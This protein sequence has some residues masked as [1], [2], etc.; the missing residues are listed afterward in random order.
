MLKVKLPILVFSKEEEIQYKSGIEVEPTL[1]KEITLYNIVG[2]M[3]DVEVPT[4]TVI[5][6]AWGDFT[7]PWKSSEVE[8]LIDKARFLKLN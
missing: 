2:I 5:Y 8:D 1:I 3:P 4:R 6:T 7:S